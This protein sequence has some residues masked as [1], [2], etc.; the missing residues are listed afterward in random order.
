MQGFA[1]VVEVNETIIKGC[2]MQPV[3]KSTHMTSWSFGNDRQFMIVGWR[4]DK[5]IWDFVTQR[6]FQNKG[7]ARP[8]L[9]QIAVRFGSRP[10]AEHY[11]LGVTRYTPQL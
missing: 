2:M 5:Q 9:A 7:I 6:S 11:T 8:Q 4:E 1:T 3:L 10:Q